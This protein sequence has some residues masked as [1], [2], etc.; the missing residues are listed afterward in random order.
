MSGVDVEKRKPARVVDFQAFTEGDSALLKVEETDLNAIELAD[1]DGVGINSDVT[2][3]GYPAI[4]DSFTDPD[5]TPT[6]QPGTVS[7][8]KTLDDGLVK[9]L[10]LS[11]QL[12]G[13]MSGGPTV[14][15][16]GNVIGI[17]SAGFPGEPFNYAVRASASRS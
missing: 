2:S 3:I 7:S 12:S 13:G 6:F 4:I 16:E 5:L 15:V 9:V 17:N 14:D 1:T 11:A 10:Q 8:L